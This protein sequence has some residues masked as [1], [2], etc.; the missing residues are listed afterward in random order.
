MTSFII[1]PSL[2][3]ATSARTDKKNFDKQSMISL[4]TFC[5]GEQYYET[6]LRLGRGDSGVLPPIMESLTVLRTTNAPCTHVDCH[7]EEGIGY[8]TVH[9]LQ[10][11]WYRAT[12]RQ[13]STLRADR[14]PN[15]C[16]L[17]GRPFAILADS[18]PGQTTHDPGIQPVASNMDQFLRSPTSSPNECAP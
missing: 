5:Y 7:L 6:N 3:T 10:M 14:H 17:S 13:E 11:P 9:R 4:S 15:P 1:H 2:S 8:D 16:F 12:R 18:Q